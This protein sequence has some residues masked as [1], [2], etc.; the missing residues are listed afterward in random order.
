MVGVVCILLIQWL[1]Y[2]PRGGGGLPYNKGGDARRE[3][4]RWAPKRY[5]SGCGL[6]EILP[7]KGTNPKHRDK[8][9]VSMNLIAI[10]IKAYL[11][12]CLYEMPFNW[13]GHP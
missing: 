5:K 3:I 8:Q 9:L 12:R 6:S 1:V 11:S 10:K 4:F 7:Q 2:A 13:P